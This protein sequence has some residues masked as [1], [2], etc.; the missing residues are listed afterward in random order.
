MS[1]DSKPLYPFHFIDEGED[2][3]WGHVSYKLADLGFKDSMTESG[4]LGGNTL[5]ELI[6]TYFERLVGDNSFEFYGTQFPVLLKTIETKAFQPLQM[7]VADDVAEQ[8]Y[9]SFGKKALWYVEDARPG[10][11]LVLGFNR[12]V[13]AEDFYNRCQNGT[14]MDVLNIVNPSAGD[15]FLIEPGTVFAAGPGLK[16]LEISECSELT[17][18]LAKLDPSYDIGD[19]EG[20]TEAFDMI[21]YGKYEFLKMLVDPKMPQNPYTSGIASCDEFNVSK[22][23]LKNVLHVSSDE[24]I[25]FTV[26]YCLSGR[27]SIQ[28]PKP[29][30]EP[31]KAG[32]M[33]LPETLDRYELKAG[34]VILMPAELT[35][36]YLVPAEDNTVL[37]ETV[38]EK[39]K[40]R[41]SYT[42]AEVDPSTLGDINISDSESDDSVDPHLREWN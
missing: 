33:P 31:V 15:A 3:P 6:G 25:G 8:R 20:L 21:N 29:G 1:E 24:A 12:K 22:I 35:D 36:F 23:D 4:W 5:S 41:D 37:L 28:V 27:T 26:Y 7:N 40:V 13:E 17:L 42:N 11:R 10:S 39:R 18:P 14:L 34:Q 38:V 9:D 32:T 2:V 16:I 30:S 19:Q